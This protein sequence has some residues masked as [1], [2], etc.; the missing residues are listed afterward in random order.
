MR[1]VVSNIVRPALAA[2]A[3]VAVTFAVGC[4]SRGPSPT[5]TSATP[6]WQTGQSGGVPVDVTVGRIVSS[7]VQKATELYQ[8]DTA[9][10]TVVLPSSTVAGQTLELLYG[11]TDVLDP[12]VPRTYRVTDQDKAAGVAA[13]FFKLRAGTLPGS[14]PNSVY[15][16]TNVATTGTSPRL[17][18]GATDN[19]TVKNG[20][21]PSS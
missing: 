7:Q 16:G 19:F 11:N 1:S 9:V 2:W 6:S 20:D 5:S 18:A 17:S 14:T 15:V 10:I 4:A 3:L 13:I 8:S 21:R 12:N